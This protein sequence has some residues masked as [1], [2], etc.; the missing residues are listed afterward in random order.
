MSESNATT[1]RSD[2]VISEATRGSID[3]IASFNVAMAQE[4][5][6]RQLDPSVVRAGVTAVVENPELGFY[7]VAEV[8]D[9]PAGCLMITNE[10]SD[11]RNGMFW[12]IQSVYVTPEHRGRG[13]YRRLYT[14][15]LRHALEDGR[16][17]GVRLYVERDNTVAQDV[18]KA[19]GMENSGYLVF[20]I[21]L[22]PD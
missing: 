4:T 5:E 6:S 3:T 11:W 15:V 10:W 16:V 7:L 2:I 22:P 14:E 21:R 1:C 20:E 12:W 18:Y 13:V 9:A 19:L 17:C 8:D